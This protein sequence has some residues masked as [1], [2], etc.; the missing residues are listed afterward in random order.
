M[1]RS[2]APIACP[3]CTHALVAVPATLAIWGCAGCG[4][5]WLGPEATVHVMRGLGDTLTKELAR[6]SVAAARASVT[7]VEDSGTRTCPVCQYTTM[8][9]EMGKVVVDS[10]PAH[11]AWFDRDEVNEIVRTCSADRGGIA[12]VARGVGSVATRAWD[13]FVAL[14]Q[15]PHP[16]E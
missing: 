6:A 8:R 9:L 12:R 14:L 11:G 3:A 15:P 16:P 4:G 13:A 7:T 5:L 10:C 2:N 1:Y